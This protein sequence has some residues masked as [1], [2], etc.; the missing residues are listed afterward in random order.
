V[1]DIRPSFR[2][3]AK[4]LLC[5]S[6]LTGGACLA[7][8]TRPAPAS[9]TGQFPLPMP[10][11]ESMPALARTGPAPV[12]ALDPEPDPEAA[13]AEALEPPT[14]TFAETLRDGMVI[15]GATP[16]RLVLFTFD[17]G[18][19][20]RNTPRLLD[21]LDEYGI[22]AVFFLTTHRIEGESPWQLEN[23]EIAREIARRGH[24]VANHTAEHAQL[25]LLESDEVIDQVRRADETL[26]RVLG[27]RAWL[28]RP[29][30]GA[31]SPRVDRLLASRG[32]TQ[33]LWNIGTGDFQVRDSD[34]VLRT[35]TRVLARRE[36]DHGERGGIVLLHDTHAW[37]VEA[38]P[39]IVSYLRDQN[40]ELLESGDELYDIVGDPRLFHA[41]RGEDASAE[42]PAARP[43]DEVLARRQR[44]LREQTRQRCDRV[45]SR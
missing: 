39:R 28:F 7:W 23:R 13:A 33:M 3:A 14:G 43:E 2:R 21:T 17:D 42:A 22:R 45:A 29:P 30:G 41:P 26:E 9:A 35:F 11:A 40:C 38:V 1:G 24:I 8:L 4:V 27:S 10:A 19:D 31:R 25:P 12:I 37:S 15:T 44:R 6:A 20:R 18:P 34:A 5:V 36:R 16:H 32:Y